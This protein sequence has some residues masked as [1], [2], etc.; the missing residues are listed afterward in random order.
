[1]ILVD[2]SVWIE[3][4]NGHT[5]FHTNKLNRLLDQQ[6]I[7]IG[8]LILIEVLQGFKQD[9]D[10]RVAD[11]LLSSLPLHTLG[12]AQLMRQS[13]MYFR[14][15]RKR[16]ITIRKTIDTIIATYCIE[17]ECILLQNDKDFEPFKKYFNLQTIE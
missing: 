12:G 1:M 5:T 3:Y 14:Q 16:G 15:L 8:D 13:A 6:E 9:K 2:S 10:Y 4:F 7:I 11:A 17:H